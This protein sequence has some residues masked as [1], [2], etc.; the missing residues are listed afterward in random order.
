MLGDT[1]DQGW[2]IKILLLVQ[3][4]EGDAAFALRIQSSTQEP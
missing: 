1:E 2:A 4:E 3:L